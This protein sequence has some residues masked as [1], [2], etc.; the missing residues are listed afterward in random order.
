[1]VATVNDIAA[2]VSLK[3]PH[4]AV[5]VIEGIVVVQFTTREHFECFCNDDEFD[6]E[7]DLIVPYY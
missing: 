2:R 6:R 3:Y 4:A 1:M 7:K 5:F